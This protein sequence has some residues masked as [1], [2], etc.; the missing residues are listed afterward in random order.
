MQMWNRQ[1]CTG[2]SGHVSCSALSS[3][4]PP[5]HTTMSG[6]ARRDSRRFHAADVSLRATCHP[7]TCEVSSTAMST[8]ASR[9]RWMPSRWRTSC[10]TPSLGTGGIRLHISSHLRCSVRA[11][12]RCDSR[13]SLDM[14]QSSAVRRSLARVSGFA[15]VLAPQP[16]QRYLTLPPEVLPFFFIVLPQDGHF[17]RCM[18]PVNQRDHELT[19]TPCRRTARE[20]FRTH[21]M[22]RRH[23]DR[24]HHEHPDTPIGR[25]LQL[26]LETHLLA[27]NP[28]V[29]CR[30]IVDVCLDTCFTCGRRG[31]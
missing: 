13:V 14:S 7:A 19:R 4:P 27:Y 30:D 20:S 6:G 11:G 29:M 21:E 2:V 24:T 26:R 8:T 5:S 22:A 17:G 25:R 12:R 10:T 3:P 18:T 1:R 9:P 16:A 23:N 15:L 28:I 31:G